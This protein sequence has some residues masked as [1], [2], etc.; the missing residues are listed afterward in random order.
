MRVRHS[1]G[2]HGDRCVGH[3]GKGNTNPTSDLDPANAAEKLQKQ[4]KECELEEQE[5][6]RTKHKDGV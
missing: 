1:H 4:Q 3:K 5:I 6:P 2:R